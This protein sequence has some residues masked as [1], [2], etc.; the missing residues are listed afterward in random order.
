M[1]HTLLLFLSLLSIA[2]AAIVPETI[3]V[4]EAPHPAQVPAAPPPATVPKA[5]TSP[6]L[7]EPNSQPKP[8]NSPKPQNTKES[9][10]DSPDSPDPPKPKK[11]DPSD[12]DNPEE[13]EV[14]K[15]D[16]PD[17]DGP[18]TT[19][20]ATAARHTGAAKTRGS[21]SGENNVIQT[22]Q[23]QEQTAGKATATRG[24]TSLATSIEYLGRVRVVLR[25]D[26]RT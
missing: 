15:P 18:T 16:T 9:E 3:P 5:P 1:R 11:P 20:K 17:G 2:H 22:V 24:S 10:T 8:N 23:G 26:W 14:E 7:Q 21:G 25:P 19:T 12:P 13:P 6:T 4:V